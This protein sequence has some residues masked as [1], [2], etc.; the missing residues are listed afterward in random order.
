MAAIGPGLNV[1][2]EQHEKHNDEGEGVWKLAK[3]NADLIVFFYSFINRN[4][5][6]ILFQCKHIN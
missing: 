1:L 4:N 2:I 3:I 5:R 6:S